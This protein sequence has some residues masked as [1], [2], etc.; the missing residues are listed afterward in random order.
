MAFGYLAIYIGGLPNFKYTNVFLPHSALIPQ[1]IY[2][3]ISIQITRWNPTS[4]MS[5]QHFVKIL[6][7]ALNQVDFPC[8]EFISDFMD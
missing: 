2:N 1:L 6:K 5:S 8:T 7:L 4:L 3:I